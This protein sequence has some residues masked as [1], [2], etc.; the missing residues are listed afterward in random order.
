MLAPPQRNRNHY[1]RQLTQ[2]LCLLHVT[3]PKPVPGPSLFPELNMFLGLP[4][5][6]PQGLAGQLAMQVQNQPD[7]WLCRVS[8]IAGYAELVGQP[9]GNDKGWGVRCCTDCTGVQY[10]EPFPNTPFLCTR[11]PVSFSVLSLSNQVSPGTLLLPLSPLRNNIVTNNI[12]AVKSC[13]CTLCPLGPCFCLHP[14]TL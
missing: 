4:N 14:V 11:R 7:S 6:P 5:Y 1:L 9:T 8:R 13:P 2:Q 10:I 3:A 12:I